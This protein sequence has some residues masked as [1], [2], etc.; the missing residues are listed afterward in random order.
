MLQKS[1]I[2]KLIMRLIPPP[3]MSFRVHTSLFYLHRNT[4]PRSTW[5]RKRI[6]KKREQGKN[7][8]R[9][10]KRWVLSLSLNL[11]LNV[12]SLYLS[13]SPTSSSP[14]IYFPLSK[15]LSFSLPFSLYTLSF[16]LPLSTFISLSQN[17]SLLISL[18][19]LSLPL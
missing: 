14:Y 6:A 16:P 11:F 2:K 3:L 17:H 1:G 8:L 13:L 12:I 15:S 18:F 10:R 5:V 4:H 9:L 19:T 7:F